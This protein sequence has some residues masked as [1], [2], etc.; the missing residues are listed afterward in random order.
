MSHMRFATPLAIFLVASTPVMAYADVTKAQ[1]IE[2]NTQAQHSRT[3]GKLAAARAQF[4]MCSDPHCPRLVRDDCTKR[5]NDLD[6]AQP[7]IIF[8]A[9]SPTGADI[10]V[11]KVSLD[12][13]VVTEK[14][15]GTPLSFDPGE[16]IFTFEVAG[17]PTITKTFVLKE[18]EKGRR[19]AL[20]ISTPP[21][22]PLVP[23]A[24][25]P[26]PAPTGPLGTRNGRRTIGLAIAGGGVVG[27]AVGS[28]F[29]ALAG[30]SSS[31]SQRECVSTQNCSN[32]SQA[33][34]EHNSAA[35]QATIS[36]IAFIA[37]GAL[38]ATGA[39]LFFTA[40]RERKDAGVVLRIAPTVGPGGAGMMLQGNF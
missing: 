38:V 33:V 20:V 36:T 11:V 23:A 14:L 7:T 27:L 26:E 6:D 31:S 24:I 25:Q 1:C 40:P 22:P 2:A 17:Q 30:S 15:D 16:H 37:G 32:R 8:E 13:T 35:T 5:L 10:S 29:G 39:V 21:P 3:D 12:N 34:S 4:E 18:G 9:K 28:I 19:E